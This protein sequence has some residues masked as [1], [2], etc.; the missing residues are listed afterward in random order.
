MQ[1][2]DGPLI[3][4]LVGLAAYM[5][6]GG[7]D[8]GVGAW[9]LTA[10]RSP[11]GE[12]IREQAHA[13]MGPVW[14]ANH[15]WLIFVLVVC[16][17]AY[18]T[19]FGSIAST[20]AIPFFLAGVGIV[21]RGSA[22]AL[23][24]GVRAGREE[25]LVDDV[26]SLSSILTPFAL[27]AI[28]G[29]IASGRVPVGNA[30]GNLVT[31]WLN[32]T[33]IVIGALAVAAAAHLAAVY[34]AADAGR[35][36]RDELVPVFR[37]RAIGSGFLAGAFA[38]AALLV[39]FWDAEPIFNG[40]TS[41]GGLAA[42][43]VSG[44]AGVATIFLV[45]RRRYEPARYTGALSVAAVIAGWAL[46]QNPVFLPG[47][48]VDEAAAGRSTLIAVL[49]AT[50]IGV[51]ILAPS[52]ALLFG[53]VLRGRFDVSAAGAAEGD[54]PLRLGPSIA[55]RTAVGVCLAL[56]VAGAGLTLFV[57]TPWALALGVAALLA[58]VA[59]GFLLL[60]SAVVGAVR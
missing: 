56:L 54:V 60:A 50:G 34:L 53:L 3:L 45:W 12:A 29:G 24:S 51:I 37:L 44:V 36:G 16:W 21:L 15:V 42:V 30:A 43:I 48:T 58:F 25:R 46:A 8:F 6:L 13:S 33:S 41:D 40:L 11:R 38:L 22:Y 27:G 17:T 14:E 19:A 52:L 23:R 26:F 49:V 28:V 4:M 39:V 1:L 20:L 57:D 59:S 55:R 31:S 18:P 32:P 5:V 47:L 2:A 7:A 9:Q 35:A 10:G